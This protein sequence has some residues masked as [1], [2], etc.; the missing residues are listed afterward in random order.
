MD[1]RY[2]KYKKY[3]KEYRLMDNA[4]MIA[5]FN[6]Q[7]ELIKYV[8]KTILG[9]NDLK[10]IRSELQKPFENLNFRYRRREQ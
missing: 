2:E 6:E 7:P 5:Y 10:I 8:I 4:F 1:S 9:R 3:I